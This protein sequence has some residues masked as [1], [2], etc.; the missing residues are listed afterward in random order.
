MNVP[1]EPSHLPYPHDELVE[2]PRDSLGELDA[3]RLAATSPVTV[4]R[5][6]ER[7]EVDERRDVLRLLPPAQAA[8]ILAEADEEAAAEALSA[9][10]WQR[11][12]RILGEVEPDDAADILAEL[13]DEDR[14]RLL[15][16]L[17][18]ASRRSIENL[19]AYE[20]ETA[21]GIMTTEVDTALDNMTVEEAT[22]R[23]REF[24]DKHEDLH[25]V[26]VVDEARHLQ[27]IVSLRK[28]IQARPE[29]LLRDVMKREIRGICEPD[30]DREEVALKMAEFNL[31]DM[32]VVDKEGKLLGV[33]T[34][35][36]VIDVLREEAT[37][38]IQMLAGAG[39]TEGLHDRIL[40]SVRQRQPWLVVNLATAF[41]AAVV[42]K[43]FED[44]IGALPLLAA[45]MP[46]IAG[47]GG[48][49][50]QQSLAITI[51][52]IA[53]GEYRSGESLTVLLRQAAI[54][55]VNGT[56]TGLV[57]AGM[58][59]FFDG[60]PMLSLIVFLAMFL[61]LALGCLA[62]TLIPIVLLRLNRD[63]A[64][65]SSIFLTFFT[66]TGGFFV[67]LMLGSVFLL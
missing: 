61:N 25:Y 63:P 50:G 32:A 8:A 37:E 3:E 58:V 28:L 19:L 36:D 43:M 64:Q 52:S 57:A 35:D 44:Q 18:K 27:G 40:S 23:I 1:V 55:L 22:R 42:V 65:M 59:F 60:P 48:N 5:F 20:P 17:E 4:A 51:R 24:A 29:T 67:F 7:L 31:P 56:L 26:Y 14:L 9:M 34:H 2:W 53:L 13:E 49:S 21:G 46:I 41:V 47:V 15:D 39:G 62:G 11:A 6:L 54:G 30:T 16:R 12:M 10:R 66:D 33:I 38:D 45:I